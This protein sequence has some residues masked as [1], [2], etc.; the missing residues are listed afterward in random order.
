MA[1][2]FADV[3]VVYCLFVSLSF[4]LLAVVQSKL[5]AV[6]PPASPKHG[7]LHLSLSITKVFGL[8]VVEFGA[9][10]HG[11]VAP[12]RRRLLRMCVAQL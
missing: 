9:I 11:F 10:Q 1:A 5:A 8:L 3:K 2:A 12:D 6:W 4:V 7:L